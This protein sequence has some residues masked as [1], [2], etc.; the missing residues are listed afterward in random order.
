MRPR[1]SGAEYNGHL[2]IYRLVGQI[3]SK[4]GLNPPQVEPNSGQAKQRKKAWISLDSLVRFEPFQR[5]APT[6]KAIFPFCSS[7]G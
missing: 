2:A 4:P 6:P 5:V 3:F 7:G 1:Q